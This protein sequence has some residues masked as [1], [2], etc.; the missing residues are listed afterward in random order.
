MKYLLIIGLFCSVPGPVD[1]GDPATGT[2]LDAE[3]EKPLPFTNIVI[4][5]QQKGSVSNIDG[6]FVLDIDSLAPGDTIL[7]SYMGYETLRIPAAELSGNS[8]ICLHPTTV[9]IREVE[10]L[11]RS[12][13]AREIVAMAARNLKKNHPSMPGRQQLFFHKYTKVPSPDKNQVTLVKSDFAGLDK[14]TFDEV[15]SMMPHEFIDY[16]DD[17]VELYSDGKD[18]RLVPQAGISLEEESMQALGRELEKKLGTLFEDIEQSHDDEEI[19]YKF[20]SGII[21]QKFK[22]DSVNDLIWEENK[23]DTLNYTVSTGEIRD[24]VLQLLEEYSMPKS[25]NWE[26]I[27]D[28]SK[29][30]YV[31]EEVTSYHDEL[32]YR[33]SFTPGKRGLFAGEMYISTSTFALLQLDFAFVEGKQSERFQILGFGHLTDFKQ[34][35]VIFEQGSSGYFVKYINARQHEVTRVDRK[36]SI[37]KKQK[38][39]LVDK[40]LNQ[41]KIELQLEMDVGSSWELLV[42]DRERME[43]GQIENIAEPPFMKFRKE[44]AYTPEMWENRTVIVPADELKKYKRR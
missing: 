25:K 4:L 30:N 14:Q 16:Q 38:R 11:Y 28:R 39:P 15:F 43:P 42:L 32:V 19:Y 7:F 1:M 23:L 35:H 29:Y 26:F 12:L 9:N 18:H 20:R 37:M 31:K 8:R 6:H 36:F 41:I 22:Q 27:N 10:V 13:S 3:T 33:I 34:G 40:E 5:G 2:V 21:S 17:I 24:A 44:Y